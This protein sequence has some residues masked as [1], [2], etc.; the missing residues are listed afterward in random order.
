MP[1]V[2]VDTVVPIAYRPGPLT[3]FEPAVFAVRRAGDLR[4]PLNVRY[5]L[6]GTAENGV[7]YQKLSGEIE[8]PGGS[9]G[10]RIQV[11]PLNHPEARGEKSVVIVLEEPVCLAI[12]PPPPGCYMVGT[13]DQARAVI[14]DRPVPQ[15]LPPRIELVQPKPNALYQAPTEIVLVAQAF[16]AEGWIQR[17]EFYANDQLIGRQEADPMRRFGPAERQGF[18]WLWTDVEPGRF[19]LEARAIDNDG[20]AA[21]SQPVAIAVMEPGA[22][23]TVRI[24][25]CAP[26]RMTSVHEG[27]ERAPVFLVT[28]SG[29]TEQPLTVYYRVGG[30]AI[31]GQGQPARASRQGWLARVGSPP[32]RVFP[33]RSEVS[34]KPAAGG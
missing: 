5:Q 33:G 28:R 30:T 24:V 13:P 21:V 25:A 26:P 8:I 9:A 29:A 2:T 12:H 14:L 17:V 16:D 6:R 22:T 23:P 19:R 34:D 27:M 20:L 1:V 4:E 15:Q 11:V 7:D 3:V 18:R 32:T 10:A 31:S